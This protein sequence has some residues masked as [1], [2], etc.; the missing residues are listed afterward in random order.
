[1]NVAVFGGTF[2]PPHVGH[3]LAARHVSETPGIDR[4]LVI[5]VFSHAFGKASTPY[6]DRLA[7]TR[8]AMRELPRV[9]VSAIEETLPAP[10]RTLHTL[11]ALA[12]RHP[13]WTFRLV[14]GSDVLAESDAWL[15]FDEVVRRAP[16]LVL[17]RKGAPHPGAP[18]AFLPEVS[19]TEL[20]ARLRA[21]DGKAAKDPWLLERVPEAVLEY[22]DAHE[23]YRA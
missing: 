15:A 9:E 12:D 23:I 16:L 13:D 21:R 2:D 5:P 10:S 14:V 4:V 19:S 11:C 7:M 22:V 3:V 8:L 6:T 18:E 20:R 1:M 17:G